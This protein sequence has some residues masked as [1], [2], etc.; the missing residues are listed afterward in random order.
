MQPPQYGT[1]PSDADER[2]VAVVTFKQNS[3][4]TSVLKTDYHSIDGRRLRVRQHT[5]CPLRVLA[6]VSATPGAEGL[7]QVRLESFGYMR[8]GVYLTIRDGFAVRLA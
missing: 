6:V 4:V 1:I 7:P 2:P 3:S 8:S 5:R